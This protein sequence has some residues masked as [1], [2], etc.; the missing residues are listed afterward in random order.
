VAGA[1]ADATGL[2]G[3]YATA[4]FDLAQEREALDAVTGDLARFRQLLDESAEFAR[5]VRSPIVS[6]DD[7]VKAVTAVADKLGMNE[8]TRNFVGYVASQRRL[9]SLAAMIRSFEALVAR[10]R[11]EVIAEVT[12]AHALTDE[13]K[14]ALEAALK[15]AVGGAVAIRT[16]VDPSLIGGLVVRV[17][18]RMIDGSI[19][20]KLHSLKLAMKGVG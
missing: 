8:L 6:R 14:S 10:A 18:S 2:A 19:R 11:G 12:S 16:D 3:R 9:F 17:G 13:Q 7:Q 4:L 15:Q 5:L 20:T 1:Q